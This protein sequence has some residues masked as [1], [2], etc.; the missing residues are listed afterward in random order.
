MS[1]AWDRSDPGDRAAA[2]VDRR[3]RHERALRTT[4]AVTAGALAAVAPPVAATSLGEGGTVGAV[5]GAVVL[6]ACAIVVW[7]QPWS[8]A[9]A[10]HLRLAAIWRQA[11]PEAD[12]DVP[13]DRFAAWAQA[14]GER[15]ALLIVGCRGTAAGTTPSDPPSPYSQRLHEHVDGGDPAAAT[16]AMERLREHVRHLE[17]QA[18]ADHAASLAAAERRRHDEALHRLDVD[19]DAELRRREAEMRREIEAGDAAERRSEADAVARA[20]RRP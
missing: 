18:R 9:E 2:D 13:W 11:R 8:R 19:A 16:E 12:D 14:D 10:D 6:L 4:A 7:R 3:R 20:L 15:V 17:A 1:H 5:M